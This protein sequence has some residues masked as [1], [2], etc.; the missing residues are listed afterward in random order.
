MNG[1]SKELNPDGDADDDRVVA[2]AWNDFPET[3]EEQKPLYGAE[4]EGFRPGIEYD[5][6]VTDH[7][8]KTVILQAGRRDKISIIEVVDRISEDIE[9][10]DMA[11]V[12]KRTATYFGVKLMLH[13]EHDGEDYN[14]VLTAPGPDAYLLLWGANTRKD[15][16]GRKWR[17]SWYPGAEVKAYLHEPDNEFRWC[18]VCRQPMETI[19]HERE[20]ALGICQR[21]K[22]GEH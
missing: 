2:P 1:P 6:P 17:S 22:D 16:D 8:S 5:G 14:Y 15:E 11:S 20:S 18:R 13:A 19:Q 3:T 7:D 21:P 12:V 9:I 4:S 10:P